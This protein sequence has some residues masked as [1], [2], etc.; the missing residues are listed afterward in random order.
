MKIVWSLSVFDN[1]Q[2]GGEKAFTC[3][4]ELLESKGVH[5]IKTYQGNGERRGTARKI[6]NNVRNFMVLLRQDIQAPI[7]QNIFNRPEFFIANLLLTIL[8]RRKIILFIHEVHEVNH[9]PFIQ[10]W[11][12]SFINYLSFRISRLIVVNSRY[13][14]NWVCSF[15]AFENKIFLMY[16]VVESLDVNSRERKKSQNGPARILCVGNIRK[17][18]GQIYLVQAME[19]SKHDF[20]IT[21]VGLVKEK[22]YMERLQ[23]YILMKGMADRVRFTGFLSGQELSEEYEKANIF[24]SPTLKEG[25]GLTVLEAMSYG[26][27]VVA[28]NV[29]AIPE[30]VEDGF[31]GLLVE[32]ENPEMLSRAIWE[33]L[34]KHRLRKQLQN[35]A[36]EVSAQFET[37]EKR[38]DMFYN[39]VVGEII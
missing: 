2:T 34:G 22:E 35:N 13:T 31:N 11:Y 28:S 15:G 25:F 17:N 19:Y 14:G 4:A 29:G 38:F 7:F 23:E 1:P 30:I 24:V 10:R 16:P 33:I 3:L 5:L 12:H 39:K 9:L 6:L 36:K 18:K 21:L 26:L 37:I 32:P 27:P 8:F 20:V